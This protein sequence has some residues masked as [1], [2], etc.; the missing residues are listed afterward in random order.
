MKCPRVPEN[1]QE[2]NIIGSFQ[3]K[4]V[5]NG[6]VQNELDTSQSRKLGSIYT[7]RGYCN[8]EPYWKEKIINILANY[9]RQRSQQSTHN[10]LAFP[11]IFKRNFIY[12][13]FAFCQEQLRKMQLQALRTYHACNYKMQ[14]L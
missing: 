6:L 5:Q 12:T 13:F 9:L 7:C 11:M 8:I 4:H 2:S 10:I 14:L 3:C 1:N